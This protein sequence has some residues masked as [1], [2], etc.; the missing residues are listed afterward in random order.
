MP[1]GGA[2]WLREAR[3]GRRGATGETDPEARLGRV[4]AAR[5][6]YRDPSGC[7]KGSAWSGDLGIAFASPRGTSSPGTTAKLLVTTLCDALLLPA[8][9]RTRLYFDKGWFLKK[10]GSG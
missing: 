8:L 9:A 10:P 7:R 6:F 5:W 1:S 3:F 4:V 2:R